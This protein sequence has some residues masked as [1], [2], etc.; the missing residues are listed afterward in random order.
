VIEDLAGR[1]PDAPPLHALRRAAR[2]ARDAFLH[3]DF[4]ALGIAMQANTAAQADLHPGLVGV[5]AQRVIAIARA[6]GALGW[7]VNGAGGDGG[8]LTILGGSA[9]GA[10]RAMLRA[11]E[12][13]DAAFRIVPIRLSPTG[14]RAWRT[15]A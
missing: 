4:G 6:H 8:S 11:I 15:V 5:D 9:L 1:G 7:K 3:G 14:V 13:E 10:H 2:G 12:T